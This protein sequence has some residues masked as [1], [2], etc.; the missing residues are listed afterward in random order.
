M[1]SAFGYAKDH[2]MSTESAY[3]YVAKSTIAY[4]CNEAAASK[5]DVKISSFTDVT[6]NS[7][8]SLK[9]AVTMQP[10]SIAIEADQLSFQSYTS[11]V[12]S[13]K[14]GTN[15]DHGVLLVG[16]GTDNG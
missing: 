14:C 10:V 15:L 3:P 5:G 6:T 7:P 12:F 16:Y 8:A 1:D 4:N 2:V 11:G 9:A 13:G